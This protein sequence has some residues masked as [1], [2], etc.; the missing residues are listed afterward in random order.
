MPLNPT[1]SVYLDAVR[2]AAA[3][4][5][6]WCHISGQ[7]LTGGLLWQFGPYGGQA[8]TIFFVLSGFVIAHVASRKDARAEKFLVDRAARILSVAWP[9]LAVT[10]ILDRL[11][12]A[13]NPTIYNA[14][15]GYIAAGQ[16]EQFLRALTFTSRL[17]WSDLSVGSNL[18]YWSLHYE[19][20]YYVIFAMATF[21]PYRWRFV[22]VLG[23]MIVAGPCIIAMFPLWLMG[24]ASYRVSRSIRMGA[25]LA[26]PLA[27]VPLLLWALYEV[28][29][30]EIGRP[31]FGVFVNRSEIVQDYIIAILFASHLVG[32]SALT[33]NGHVT[34][35]R[36]VGRTIQWAAGASF[37]L[38]LL[39]LPVAQFLGAFAPWPAAS[40]ATR[41]LVVGGTLAIVFILAEFTERR[42]ATWRE[43]IQAVIRYVRPERRLG[44][45]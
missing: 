33:K 17:W 10:F 20:W 29:V 28:V 7:R 45:T 6:F 3:M 40:W 9:A 8:V 37:S 34:L 24:V 27:V 39:H 38:Y 44:N 36:A 32:V 26:L 30:R 22:A 18:P 43:A 31:Y 2:F 19:V 42:K 16:T 23:T 41:I 13:Y 35:P 25:W 5:V 12:S 1:F 15:W 11:G 21:A 4:V 14:S